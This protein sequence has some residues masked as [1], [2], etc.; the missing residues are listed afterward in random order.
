MRDDDVMSPIDQLPIYFC[1]ID[2]SENQN[3]SIRRRNKRRDSQTAISAMGG[4]GLIRRIVSAIGS[5]AIV[6]AKHEHRCAVVLVGE[7]DGTN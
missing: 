7:R 6:V 5:T 2:G 3:R 4:A 1:S